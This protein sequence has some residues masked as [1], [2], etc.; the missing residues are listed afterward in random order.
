MIIFGIILISK[1]VCIKLLMETIN[2]LSLSIALS[3]LDILC[4]DGSYLLVHVHYQYDNCYLTN[5]NEPLFS[6]EWS[7]GYVLIEELYV[8]LSSLIDDDGTFLQ[9]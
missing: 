3:R 1:Q 7:L 5:S 2:G 4:M 8:E 6:E 9:Y